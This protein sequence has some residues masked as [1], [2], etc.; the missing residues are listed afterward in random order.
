MFGLNNAHEISLSLQDINDTL[1]Y[2]NELLE[3]L[4]DI[5]AGESYVN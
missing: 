5:L 2:Q 4:K 1:S 3:Q